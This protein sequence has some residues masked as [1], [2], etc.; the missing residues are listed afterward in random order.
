MYLF[1]HN[2]VKRTNDKGEYYTWWKIRLPHKIG[3]YLWDNVTPT[4]LHRCKFNE[5][6]KGQCSICGRYQN[7]LQL[8]QRS[9]KG[10]SNNRT[11]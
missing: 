5:Y 6:I 4:W 10:K 7:E 3:K 11:S 9:N 2:V 1:G 8:R